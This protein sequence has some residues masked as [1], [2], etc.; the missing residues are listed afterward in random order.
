MRPK[1]LLLREI[2]NVMHKIRILGK[3]TVNFDEYS[4]F[5]NEIQCKIDFLL[6]T[7]AL[8]MHG[9]DNQMTFGLLLKL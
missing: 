8:C 4:Q 6:D 3:L 1:L 9:E 5:R 2:Y 7:R